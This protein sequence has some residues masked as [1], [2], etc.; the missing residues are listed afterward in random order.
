MVLTDMRQVISHARAG[1]A[2]TIYQKVNV[3]SQSERV[4][5]GASIIAMAF[6]SEVAVAA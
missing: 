4:A 1:R 2:Q 5:E 6:A 3:K